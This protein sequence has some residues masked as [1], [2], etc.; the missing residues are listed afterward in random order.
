M[1]TSVWRGRLAFG[2]VSIPVRLFK[3]AR[4]ERI[5]F[6]KVYRPTEIAEPTTPPREG[7]HE[8][9]EPALAGPPDEAG[10]V[11]TQAG[12][13]GGEV[14]R[15]HNVATG[16]GG[17]EPLAETEILKGYE[18]S[19]DRYVT[20][21]PREIAALRPRTSTELSILEFVRLSEIDP[22][23]FD[24]SYYLAPDGGGQKAYALLHRA[25]AESGYAALGSFAMHGREH[26]ALIR[27]GGHGLILHTLYRAGEVR[28]EEEYRGDP[29]LVNA[30]ELELAK[31]LIGA[32]AA[33]FDP[34]KL[35]DTFEERLRT[36]IDARADR[37]V[38]AYQRGEPAKGA[39]VVDIM[40]AL[41]KSLE[42]VRKPPRSEQAGT[43]IRRRAGRR[44]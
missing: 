23:F 29:A 12:P 26:A 6:H 44:R 28:A 35:K 20:F 37:A 17:G 40:Q 38:E 19:K 30:K 2:M 8:I 32:L 25:L 24:T 21:E 36:L 5:R 16:E 1:A 3:A 15:V 41:R 14:A 22:L 39:P 34:E 18:I 4:R 10:T 11:D 42:M 7:I 31:R 33:R 13:P 27:P 9:S 43:T